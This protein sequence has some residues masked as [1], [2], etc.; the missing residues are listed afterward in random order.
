MNWERGSGY[1]TC[2][3]PLLLVRSLEE[4]KMCYQK[5]DGHLNYKNYKK[6]TKNNNSCTQNT[7]NSL[8][9]QWHCYSKSFVLTNSNWRMKS[10]RNVFKSVCVCIY[11]Y[12][13]MYNMRESMCMYMWVDLY[14]SVCICAYVHGDKLIWFCNLMWKKTYLPSHKVG[15]FLTNPTGWLE[16]LSNCQGV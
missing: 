3:I 1:E 14:S 13:Y 9:G 7:K 8:D 10:L 5:S 16:P 2:I 11:I 4:L 12:M 15:K 6:T